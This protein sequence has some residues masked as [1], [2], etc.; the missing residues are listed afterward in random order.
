MSGGARSLGEA[1][2]G[3]AGGGEVRVGLL[4]F[5]PRPGDVRA[6]L[7]TL[8]R[9]AGRAA[10]EGARLLVA[11]ELCTTGYYMGSVFGRLAEPL[12]GPSV[13]VVRELAR[14]QGALVALGMA[15]RGAAG[16]LHDSAVLVGPGGAMGAG[17]K[18]RLWDREV[19]VFT[20]GAGA[21]VATDLGLVGLLVCYDLEHP[22]L[23]RALADAGAS[24]IVAVAAFSDL[25]LWRAT[26]AARAREVGVPIVAANRT[27]HEAAAVFCGHSMA[28]AAD[29]SVVVEA[30][31]KGGVTVAL[32]RAAPAA[33]GRRRRRLD[34]RLVL[35][36]YG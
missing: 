26:L 5:S 24:L 23:V 33:T 10:Q 25:R 14:R 30:G 36:E 16:A 22:D 9:L 35:P 27:G 32:V 11:P 3:G 18:S 13:G 28:V 8:V 34:P 17:R 19:G 6:N 7:A 2:D 21:V 29:G 31:D 15:E 12:D 4:Q 20:P 1:T